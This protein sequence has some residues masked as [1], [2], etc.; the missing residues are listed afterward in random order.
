MS[1]EVIKVLLIEDD[2]DDYLLTR[3]ML[4]ADGPCR[5]ELTWVTTYEDA[6]VYLKDGGHDVCVID[7]HLGE[8][9]GVELLS[10]ANAQ[11]WKFPAIFLT[12]K[13]DPIVD[14]EAIKAGAMDYL[15]K[16]QI[17]RPLL[18]RSIRYAIERGKALKALRE[19]EHK[20]RQI[21]ETAREGI[22]VIDE[23]GRTTYVN[24]RTIEMLGYSLE[25]ML[26]R[27][28]F[29]FLEGESVTRAKKNFERRKLGHSGQHEYCL[30]HKNGTV[31][32]V[33]VSTNPVFKAD[34][35]FGGAFAMITD[36]TER[37]REE[38]EN[39]RLLYDLKERVKELGAIHETA[40]ILQSH[41]KEIPEL[42]KEVVQILP[43][44]WQY[45]EI[46][47]ARM[48]YNGFEYKTP[49][50]SSTAWKQTV[51]F[52]TA[53]GIAGAIEVVY[54]EERPQI[55]E[56]PFLIEERNLINSVA[57]MLRLE[58]D[59][60]LATEALFES[61]TQLER[62][63]AFALVMTTHVGLDGRWLKVPPTLCE[64]LGYTE[65]ELLKL[66]YQDLTHP[67][68][69]AHDVKQ[70]ERLLRGELK[71][72]DLEKRYRRK[73]GNIVWI[74]LNCSLVTDSKGSPVH[75]LT[76]I[77]DITERKRVTEERDLYFTNALDMVCIAG[78][79]GYFKQVNPAW[80]R[81]LGYTD[82]EL[83][84]APY[85]EFVHPD[86]RAAT[87]EQAKQNGE[88]FNT[89]SFENRYRSKDGSYRWL[90]WSS[91]TSKDRQIIYGSARDI[92]EEKLTKEK[93]QE[94]ERRFRQ[95]AEN[96]N[97]V[98]WISTPDKHEVLYVSPAYEEI[99]GRSRESLYERADS[100]LDCIHP[101]DSGRVRAVVER[102]RQGE[103][104][105]DQYRVV[106]A[107]GSIRWVRD[108]AFAVKDE[109]AV[110]QRLVG[111]AEDITERK[112]AEEQ[113]RRQLDFTEAITTSLGEGVYALDSMGQVTF[114]NP[115]AETALGWKKEELLGRK[116]HEVIHFQYQDGK[117][118]P[119]ADCPLLR[120]LAAGG[121]VEIE[122]DVF[123]R[124]DGSI[125]HVSYTSA[126]IINEGEIAGVVMAFRDITERK[127]LEEKF[128]QSQKMEAVGR[129]AGGIAHDFNNILT[130]ITGY[131]DLSLRRL[132]ENSSLR[133][134]IEEIRKAAERAANLT[135][136]LL[137]FSRQQ[138]LQPKVLNLND[139]VSDMDKMLRRLI[140][141]DIDLMCISEREL[142]CVKADPGQIEQVIM[143]L[144]VNSRDAMPRGG[145]LTIETKNI[146]LDDVYAS[147]HV[148]V[149]PGA[150]V[151][152][153]ISD[154]GCG[155]NQETQARI[156]EP[157]FTTKEL[158][159]GTGLGLSTVYGIVKQSGGYV[160]V[161][162]EVGSGTTF[163][164]YL[165]R[166]DDEAPA[167]KTHEVMT[168]LPHGTET[169]LVVEDEE[170]V[171]RM[172]RQVL[173]LNG[174]HVLEAGHGNEA[175]EI[176]AHYAEP[177]H[178][179][180]TDVVMPQMGGKELADKINALRPEI[181][182]LFMSGYTDDA[183][184]HHGVLDPHVAFLQKPFVPSAL[185]RK[186]REVLDNSGKSKREAG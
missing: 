147:Q 107:D 122:D 49:R 171:R 54:L 167:K 168:S 130:A 159:K 4:S 57:E 165:P 113:L 86:D 135:R 26:G 10:E 106:R 145:K 56:G 21:V 44:A 173:E 174:Y 99:W 183:I 117:P 98:F 180:L 162:S 18:E 164:I 127:T 17:T 131:S 13:D 41:K 46:T 96:I 132:E 125:F 123:T 109:N 102:L 156:F 71:S 129:L 111:I 51:E 100:Y 6:I 139:V 74:Y 38:E 119:V 31:L 34:G 28:S 47:A 33:I 155:M 121:V 143:N 20:Y 163:K 68:D 85:L 16:G 2:E 115:A 94:S 179:L 55:S 150:Y 152:L 158:G 175:L 36:I 12:G 101:E 58:L 154:T 185:A 45:P 64:L 82:E 172:A 184:V 161:Y 116:M 9:T 93:L 136:Q 15:I 19:S 37:K 84:S 153:M 43:P 60:R 24:H 124:K 53:N 114:V 72:Y 81:T 151:M 177:I 160:W 22:W 88:G 178:L 103:N 79:D 42:L 80:G 8:R 29:D 140:G 157:F 142:G 48:V 186:V 27:V 90:S 170:I 91:T 146:Y 169:V 176:C 59:R 87:I 112:H 66:S 61:E 141:E 97:E 3:E 166:V 110:V 30:R 92:T 138:M 148:S 25:E 65:E 32:W 50:Y 137:A 181:K 73:D 11:D 95:L 149:E 75:F 105:D 182:V 76:Y 23:E 40:R 126:P 70:H 89:V 1:P 120:V 134:N 14:L 52:R 63:Q 133:R 69:V 62:A 39:K 7:Y 144:V 128:R 108:R 67:E 35:Q 5:F 104:R 83:L 118:R 77:I 78:F